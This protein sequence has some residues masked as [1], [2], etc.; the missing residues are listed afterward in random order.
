MPAMVG[1]KGKTLGIPGHKTAWEHV[2]ALPVLV[3]EGIEE[4]QE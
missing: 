3:G 4:S 2:L 1:A